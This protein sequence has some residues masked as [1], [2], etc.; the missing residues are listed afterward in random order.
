MDDLLLQV[1]RDDAESDTV[2]NAVL[3]FLGKSK[4]RRLSLPAPRKVYLAVYRLQGTVYFK[5]LTRDGF[6]LVQALGQGKRLA[7]AI[8]IS[9]RGSRRSAADFKS[10][11]RK[12]FETWAALG[13]FA[14]MK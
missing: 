9:L 2:S 12:W 5:R 4:S 7:E 1:R 10:R 3:N 6:A 8:E 14:Q 13:W 11:L